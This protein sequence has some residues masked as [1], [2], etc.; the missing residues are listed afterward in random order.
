MLLCSYFLQVFFHYT[1]KP[2]Q[3]F[4]SLNGDIL[5][6]SLGHLVAKGLSPPKHTFSAFLPRAVS[7]SLQSLEVARK[8]KRRITI[9]HYSHARK[10]YSYIAH[11]SSMSK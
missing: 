8:S 3:F 10:S 4:G 1:L 7:P 6:V 11:I 5:F 9:L 2:L